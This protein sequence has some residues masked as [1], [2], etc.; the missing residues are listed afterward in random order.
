MGGTA[1][2]RTG[3]VKLQAQLHLKQAVMKLAPYGA[4]PSRSGERIRS[5][6]H[7]TPVTIHGGSERQSAA[8]D[9]S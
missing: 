9:R 1:A 8:L 6:Q 2:A 7:R 4:T 3:V 5:A